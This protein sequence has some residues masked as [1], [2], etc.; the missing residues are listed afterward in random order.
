MNQGLIS[1]I[2]PRRENPEQ[3][4]IK[5]LEAAAHKVPNFQ[6]SFRSRVIWGIKAGPLEVR[7]EDFVECA[8]EFSKKALQ[9]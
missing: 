6:I 3:L 1:V 4:A 8:N 2:L 9:G 5:R 7:H